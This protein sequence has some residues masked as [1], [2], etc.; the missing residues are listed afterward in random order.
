MHVGG[1]EGGEE[2]GSKTNIRPQE[3][4]QGLCVCQPPPGPSPT[5]DIARGL[6]PHSYSHLSLWARRPP[7]RNAGW[8]LRLQP[9]R[10]DVGRSVLY[11]ILNTVVRPILGSSTL[12]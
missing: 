8:Y 12:W 11:I 2:G 10:W 6:H 3:D 9:P 5:P 1:G 4:G 7:L